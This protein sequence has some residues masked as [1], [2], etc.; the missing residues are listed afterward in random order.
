MPFDAYVFA[1]ELVTLAKPLIARVATHDAALAN[2]LRRAVSSPPL[3][4][5]EGR[6][7]VGRDRLHLWRVAAGSVAEVLA[8]LEVA[9]A[10][11]YLE[12]AETA[13]AAA[14]CDRLGAITW[15]LTR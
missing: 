1:I 11:G 14:L 15:R 12:G 9:A 5:A 4:L 2:Q 6:K 3:N 10:M 13:E 8:A 7:R